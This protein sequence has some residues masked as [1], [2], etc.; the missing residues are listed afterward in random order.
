MAAEKEE[1][2][3]EEEEDK[4]AEE[5]KEN[6]RRAVHLSSFFFSLVN[7]ESLPFSSSLFSFTL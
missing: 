4:K 7:Y 6:P 3:E 5:V 1:E 2:E